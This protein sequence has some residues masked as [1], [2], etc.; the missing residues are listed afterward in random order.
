V[1]ALDLTHFIGG[2]WTAA[3]GDE[4]IAVTNPARP[5]ETVGSIPAGTSVDVDRAVRAARQ[6]QPGWAGRSVDERCEI[7]KAAGDALMAAAPDAAPTLTREM[8]KVL[9]ESVM[10]FGAPGF[11]WNAIADDP[12]KVEAA[13]S[14]TPTDDQFGTIH[15]RRR[16]V[17]VVGAIVPWNWP[18]AL[19]GVKLGPALLAGNTVVVVP[20]PYASLSVL[21][22]IEAMSGVLPDGV[23]NVV[24][25]RGPDVGAA[26]VAHPGVGMVAFTGGA[27]AGRAVAS[28]AG[29]G[30]KR[31]ILELGGNDAAVL[32]DDVEVDDTLIA[33]LAAAF[34]MTSGQVCFAI[35]RLYVHD[36]LFDEV[37]ARLADALSATVVG[38][39]LEP[40]VTMGP[41]ANRAQHERFDRIL[42]EAER[43]GAKVRKLGT[44]HDSVAGS[45]GYF[46]LPALVT[47]VDPAARLVV[48]EQFGPALPVLPF[49]GDASVVEHVNGTDFGLTT[50]VWSSDRARARGLAAQIDA[51]VCFVNQHGL[52]AFDLGSPFG[53]TKQSGYGREMGIEGL[54]EFTWTQ[55]I[56]DRHVSLG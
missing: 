41:L 53:G 33:T 43:A 13:L 14:S 26:L 47:D 24:A 9:A 32:L 5:G 22:A 48:E 12:Q 40:N 23:V 4:R 55:Q 21:Q 25:G 39:G 10:D 27:E 19:L 20:S 38:D 16:P 2:S 46:H 50:S 29:T 52:A 45:G 44:F 42:H 18:L 31:S 37:V 35:K 3:D 1:S 49:S 28:G 54:L 17:G 56:N 11:G 15:L 34:A 7:V 6:A 51:G 30:L 36:S 8:G